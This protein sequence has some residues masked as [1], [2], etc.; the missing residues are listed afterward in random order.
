MIKIVVPISGGKDSQLCLQL[1]LSQHQ[2]D[3]VLGLFCDTQFEHPKT[4]AHVEFIARH[5]GVRIERRTGGNVPDKVR[6]HKR[7]PA[8]H[9]RFCTDELKIRVS[10]DFYKEFV[11]QNGP[12]EVWYG[13]R[14]AESGMRARRYAGKI[15]SDLYAPHEFMPSKYPKLLAKAGVMFRLPIIDFSEKQVLMELNGL[16][17]PLYQEGFDRVGC[18]PCLASGDKWKDKAFNHDEFGRNQRTIVIQLERDIGKR[19]WTSKAYG[20]GCA[21]C[22]Y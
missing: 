10:R 5:Y 4:Y 20:P 14:T 19:V 13:M 8:S 2:P 6:K 9:I 3:E 1:A 17:N 15:S 11:K 21:M 16:E 12:F 7:F 22:S 18:F